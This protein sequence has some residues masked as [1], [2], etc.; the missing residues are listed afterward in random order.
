MF[1]SG[2]LRFLLQIGVFDMTLML[3]WTL[4]DLRAEYN[5]V[6]ETAERL[7]AKVAQQ[8]YQLK[9]QHDEHRGHALMM[10]DLLDAAREET[11]KEREAQQVL[12]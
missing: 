4:Q 2:S 3:N 5:S 6:Q 8:Q 10:Q 12:C 11:D 1:I 7:S 9:A